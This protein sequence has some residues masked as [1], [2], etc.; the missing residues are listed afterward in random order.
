[1]KKYL[2]LALLL[3]LGACSNGP[4]Q[5]EVMDEFVAVWNDQN[6]S[7]MYTYLSGE[8]QDKI[9]K[10][11]FVDRY[12]TIYEEVEVEEL[13]V[14]AG[15]MAEEDEEEGDP[16]PY[17]VSME[18]LAGD[19]AFD[20]EAQLVEEETEDGNTWKVNWGSS[21]IFPELGV[22]ETVQV[23]PE[24]P[25][26]GDILDRNHKQL[27]M[28]AT[29]DEV[30]IVP[31][32]MDEDTVAEV[33][34]LTDVPEDEIE[35]ALDADWA[36]DDA[37]VPV[38]KLEPGEDDVTEDLVESA[39]VM[40]QDSTSRYYPLAEKAAHL[41]GYI[42]EVNAEDLE[43]LPSD[44]Y[45]TG[46]VV[47]STGLESLYEEKLRGSKGWRI[48]IPESEEVIAET[49]VEDGED[50]IT[51][52][53]VDFQERMFAEMD[54][55]SG[56]GV[57]LQPTTGETIGLV[58]T[59]AYDPNHFI[60]GW[61]EGEFEEANED[62]DSPFSAKFNNRYAPGSTIKPITASI[63][64][65]DDSLEADEKKN[66]EGKS[67]QPDD[68]WGGYEVTRV[69]D[70]LTEVNLKDALLTSDNIY[71][72]QAALDTGSDDFIDGLHSFGF[73][74]DVPYEFPVI[75]SEI[76]E[77]GLDEDILL[78]DTGYGQGEM[79]MS[80]VHL[81]AT[82]TPFL[83]DGDMLTPTL[84]YQEEPR[85]TW[86]EEV[87]PADETET[88][89]EGIRGVVENER[90]SA[91]EPVMEDLTIAG[92]TGTAE[93]KTSHEEDDDVENGWFVAYD[94]QDEDMLISMMIEDVED[95]GGSG[96]TV[97]K[98]KNLFD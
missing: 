37:F 96:Y 78:A 17:E 50:V 52:I 56:A 39:G 65:K 7:E 53:D 64:L 75:E 38:T 92:K 48:L 62:P 57:A 27:A 20:G 51:T 14:E 74:E 95:R 4:T 86:N 18:T 19:V 87:T 5:E 43:E 81:A 16:F 90:G 46:S 94:Y 60:F 11:A 54:G 59:P 6:F 29:V 89:T 10:N 23:I 85:Q 45:S 55:D 91:Y 1:M 3:G 9:D 31:G 93:L 58:S 41:T 47:G 22:G 73:E 15:N 36:M 34:E 33:S 30:G 35:T 32:K 28:N 71:F 13:V 88:I 68:S 76:A 24:E 77:D 25:V 26:R 98:V 49:E 42:R 72:A 79:L 21:F 8:V 12:E 84:E 82:F 44:Q 97:E 61:P 69:S 70:R 80:P 83:N 40:I 63:A 2:S 67:W 66:I